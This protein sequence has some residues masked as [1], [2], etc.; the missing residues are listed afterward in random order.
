MAVII[1]ITGGALNTASLH[2]KEEVSE[3]IKLHD[4]REGKNI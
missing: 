4:L 3:F 2:K 1:F